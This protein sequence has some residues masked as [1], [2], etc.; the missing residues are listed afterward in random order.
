MAQISV[1][2]D[3]IIAQ[4]LPTGAQ[5]YLNYADRLNQLPLGVIGIAVG[6]VLL[7]ELTRRLAADDAAGAMASQNRAIELTLALTLPCAIAFL[8]AAEPLLAAMFERGRFTALDS[9]QSA[10]TLTAYAFGLPAFVLVRCL[11]PGFYARGDTATPVKIAVATVALNVGLKIALMGSLSQVGLAVGTSAGVWLNIVLLAWVLHRRGQ[12]R[13]DL[14]ARRRLPRMVLS[15]G[16][17]AAAL[18]GL[19]VVAAP[20]L[21]GRSNLTAV[22]TILAVLAAAGLVYLAALFG[23]GAIRREDLRR[24]RRR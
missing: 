3:T 8:V 4:A 22:V 9:H 19:L 2:A 11:L 10:L 5:S 24:L 21:A 23:L 6:T 16:V 1:F 17:M 20:A 13:L 15:G 7:P 18:W 14:A 12:F